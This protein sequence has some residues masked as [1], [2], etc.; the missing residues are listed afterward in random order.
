MKLKFEAR[1]SRPWHRCIRSQGL[2]QTLTSSFS[3]SDNSGRLAIGCISSFLF[4]EV[5][6][7]E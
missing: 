3:P 5:A 7:L 4:P 1:P 2:E 6:T